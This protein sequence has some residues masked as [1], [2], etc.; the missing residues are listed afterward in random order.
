MGKRQ[1]R[2]LIVV[3]ISFVMLILWLIDFDVAATL[4]MT[5]KP[6][7]QV[8][9]QKMSSAAL[10]SQSETPSSPALASSSTPLLESPMSSNDDE[11]SSVKVYLYSDAEVSS[12]FN[13][14]MIP[15]HVASAME[16]FKIKDLSQEKAYDKYNPGPLGLLGYYYCNISFVVESELMET[17]ALNA[18]MHFGEVH[19]IR[20]LRM[21]EAA[22]HPLLTRIAS[23]GTV[24][25]QPSCNLFLFTG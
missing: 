16:Y 3:V 7:A 23:T 22:S 14:G 10:S 20:T 18:G 1:T 5:Q 2:L 9:I 17:S 4:S 12:M 6:V 8:S 21:L 24:N 15:L 19:I 25:T 11:L 13:E